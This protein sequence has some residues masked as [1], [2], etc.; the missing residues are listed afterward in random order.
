MEGFIS[1]EIWQ[2]ILLYI[3]ERISEVEFTT[4]FS[5]VKMLE[6]KDGELT[7]GVR[8][9]FA[10]EWF[11]VHYLELIEQ[12]LGFLGAEHPKVR[13]DIL[14]ITAE[15]PRSL[16]EPESTPPAES[17]V[18][19]LPTFNP[20]LNHKYTFD[21]FVIGE[22]NKM[23][24]AASLR[25]AEAPGKTYNPL[26]I[27]GDVG[28]GKTHLMHAVGHSVL[29]HNPNARVEYVSTETFTNELINAIR[30]DRMAE[31]RNRY[32]S[33]DLLLVDDIQFLAGKERTQEEFFHTF[34]ALH[35][36]QKQII[37]SSDRPPK[38]IQTLEARLR[39]RFEW[40]LITDI[41]SPDFETRVAILKMNAQNHNIDISQD[42][43]EM[44]ARQVTNNIRELEGALVR[45]V[46]YR[47]LN[48]VEFSRS[49]VV[50]ALSE[51]FSD[52]PLQV[53]MPDLLRVVAQ[54]FNVSQEAIKGSGRTREVALPRQM[55]MYL[56]REMTAYSLPEIGHFFGRDHTTVLHATHKIS[57]QLAKD[58]AL[59][60]TLQDIKTDIQ[61]LM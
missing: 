22:N 3:K 31:F 20:K 34:N 27:Y 12:A 39:S 28:L 52:T 4:W 60:K 13:F 54:H 18:A 11:K 45:V 47:S 5:N 46:A 57:E 53:E 14:A 2:N 56:I 17:T 10:Q 41:Q 40:G 9:S 15:A 26:F 37:L 6:L 30:E 33:I 29:Q 44:I 8:N 1:Q 16:F 58:P 51:V 49:T 48:N 42:V 25:V 59:S 35:E 36:N 43:L 32:R 55:A 7:L 21:R 23:A 24:H 19:T 38:D 61:S 50:R